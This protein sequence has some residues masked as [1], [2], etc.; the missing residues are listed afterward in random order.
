MTGLI[1]IFL[2]AGILTLIGAGTLVIITLKYYWGE[3][4]T[5]PMSRKDRR[6]AREVELSL[7]AKQIEYSQTHP[8]ATRSSSFFNNNKVYR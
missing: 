3:R 8:I 6:L 5:P 1:G 4:G 7:R 2:A